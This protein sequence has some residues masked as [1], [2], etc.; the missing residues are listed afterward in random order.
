[1]QAAA[2][3]E[4]TTETFLWLQPR[5]QEQRQQVDE[6]PSVRVANIL[7]PHLLWKSQAV[8]QEAFWLRCLTLEGES[9]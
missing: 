8:V 1:M 5:T 9:P 2:H 7:I 3:S 4:V 6:T